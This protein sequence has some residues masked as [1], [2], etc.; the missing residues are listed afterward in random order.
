M[1]FEFKTYELGDLVITRILSTG[2]VAMPVV[3]M[4]VGVREQVTDVLHSGG[5]AVM[6]FGNLQELRSES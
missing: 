1:S 3:A 4:I 5:V 6:W 2:V